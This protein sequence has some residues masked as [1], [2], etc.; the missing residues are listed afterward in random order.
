MRFESVEPLLI[1]GTSANLGTHQEEEEARG[2]WGILFGKD[3]KDSLSV[4]EGKFEDA[5]HA[6]PFYKMTK[7]E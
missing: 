1:L 2:F 7:N 4:L 5:W 3:K 6:N